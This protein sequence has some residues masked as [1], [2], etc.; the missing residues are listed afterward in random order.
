[1]KEV[2]KPN[3]CVTKKH[4]SAGSAGSAKKGKE[5]SGNNINKTTESSPTQQ[6]NHL[7][8]SDIVLGDS[9]DSN[10]CSSNDKNGSE[11]QSEFNNKD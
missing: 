1:M 7:N 8:T 2:I 9:S 3:L 4:I 11:A 5:K 6:L 10:K